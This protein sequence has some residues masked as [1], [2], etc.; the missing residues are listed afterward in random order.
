[1]KLIEGLKTLKLHQKKIVEIQAL[2]ALNSARKSIEKSAYKDPTA[3]VAAWIAS[4]ES[5][6]FEAERL[7]RRIQLTNLSTQVTVTLNGQAITKSISEWVYRRRYGAPNALK[8][9]RMLTDR[10][11]KPEVMK[12]ND[13]SLLEIDVVRHFDSEHR[14]KMLSLYHDEPT[15]IDMALEIVNATTDLME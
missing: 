2:I 9:Y 5:H 10:N 15:I 7:T 3:Q 13:G 8:T 11:L 1:M 6:N 14:D 4:S 12:Q